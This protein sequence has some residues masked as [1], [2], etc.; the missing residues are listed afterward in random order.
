MNTNT[1]IGRFP[2]FQKI[3]CGGGGRGRGRTEREGRGKEG[4]W[5][6]Y[7]WNV[8]V[9]PLP[10]CLKHEGDGRRASW[11]KSCVKSQ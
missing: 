8:E 9:P 1:A 4:R 6:E 7:L 10:L 11:V 5:R 2:E 3:T